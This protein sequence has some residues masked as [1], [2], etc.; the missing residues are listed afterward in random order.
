[1]DDGRALAQGRLRAQPVVTDT[2]APSRPPLPDFLVIGAQKS[3][4]RWLRSNLG[5]HPDVY[6][7]DREMVF[8]SSEKRYHQLGLAWYRSQFDGWSGEQ[9][10]GEG[11]PAYMM[12]RHHP[13]RVVERIDESLPGVRPIA[14][15]RNPIDRAESAMLHHVQRERVPAHARLVDVM[16]NSNPERDSLGLVAGGWYA[17]SLQPYHERFGDRLLVLFHDDLA[18]DA[19]AVYRS[20]ADHLGLDS[21][22]V[23]PQLERVVASNRAA[24]EAPS[25]ALSVEDRVAMW[26]YFR[27]DVRALEEMTGRDLHAW[28]PTVGEQASSTGRP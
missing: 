10:V 17:R 14:I 20:A 23:P 3:A 1:M 19:M 16:R 18:A 5:Q 26:E 11:T 27:D 28:D 12:W 8:F 24:A 25:T 22:F 15:L 4:T 13:E 7:M 6:Y 21:A 9:H 2:A